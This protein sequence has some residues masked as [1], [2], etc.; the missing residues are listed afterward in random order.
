ML[1]N[2]KDLSHKEGN[3]A[4]AAKKRGRKPTATPTNRRITKVLAS[5]S[6]RE[7]MLLRLRFGIGSEA[8]HTLNELRPRFS[9][10]P[11]RLGR[12][13]SNAFSK[14]RHGSSYFLSQTLSWVHNP[15][16]Y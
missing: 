3:S 2:Q 8:E 1:D 4:G 14:L 11:Q 9:L 7:E 10:P 15:S 5:L 12:I 16:N 13:Q 6:P